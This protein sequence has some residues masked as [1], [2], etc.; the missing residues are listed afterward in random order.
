VS[1]RI[2]LTDVAWQHAAVR[3]EID[4]GIGALLSD[5]DCDGLPF[6]HALEAAVA[7]Y[8]GGNVHAIAVQS[9]TAAEFLLLKALG[10]G[11]DDEVITV[12]N[13]D[14]A[15]NA[16]I[17][18]VGAKQK[19]VDVTPLGFSIDPEA[20]ERAIGPATKAILP[21]HMH[22]IPADMSAL[23]EMA[24]RRGLLLLEDATLALGARV[25]HEQVGMLGDGAFFSFAPRKVIGGTGNG[26]MVLTRDPEVARRVRMY[27]GYGQDPAVMDLPVAERQRIGGQGHVVEGYNLKLD[28]IQAIV[29]LA[30]FRHLDAW[31]ALRAAAAATYDRELA[32]TPGLELPEVRVG[33]QPAWRNYT[34]RSHDRDGL[35]AHLQRHHIASGTLY[36]PPVHLQPVYQELGYREGAFPVAERL[37]RELLNLPIY[38]GIRDEQLA[39]VVWAVRAF[40]SQTA[41]NRAKHERRT[42]MEP[43]SYTTPALGRRYVDLVASM[44]R[45]GEAPERLGREML[46]SNYSGVEPTMSELPEMHAALDEVAAAVEGLDGHPQAYMRALVRSSRALLGRLAG[47][48]R[49]YLEMVRDI[50]EVDLR[51][52]PNRESARLREQLFDGLGELGYRGSLEDRVSAWRA[53]T[54]IT[55]DAVIELAHG[56]MARARAA[57][58]ERVLSLPEGEGLDEVFGVRNV[59]YSGRSKYTGNYRGWI[60]F[61]I[62]KQWQKDV[63]VQVLAHEGY[64]GHQA[65]YAV[66]DQLFRSGRW[67]VE[68]AF[69]QRNAP[70]NTVFEGGPESALH[71]LGWDEGDSREALALRLGQ[72]SKDLGRIAMQNACMWVNQGEMTRAQAV[73]LMVDHFVLRDD[74]ERAFAF[75]TDPVS[76]TNYPQYYYGRRIVKL[77]FERFEGSE[78][79]RQ[80][81][82]D[83]IY[84][85]PHTTS[86][87]IAAVAEASGAPF[88]PFVYPEG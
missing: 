36:A 67:P 45:Y 87:F 18:H 3:A 60:H 56:V 68:A 69:Y 80:R 83:L 20:V 6:V 48:E 22:G 47:E 19:W 53:A 74:A 55:G 23:R 78:G 26:G 81:F 21:V 32:G 41:P 9:G 2:P 37:G 12:C 15:T 13:S 17:S 1:E 29:I 58:E 76:R 49:P 85:T 28:G 43:L 86:T 27:R 8:H 10:I 46:L 25:G 79:D 42:V 34:V 38:P 40:Q 11:A 7:A 35:R 82:F 33:D 71:F 70:T 24:R 73:E 57:T 16:A 77:A 5:P 59:F 44:S 65:F 88:D 63:F 66:W 14:L 62:D 84:R 39:R 51:E 75:F 50:L 72:I 30:K 54:S 52:I 4:A 64:P 61:N 31:R